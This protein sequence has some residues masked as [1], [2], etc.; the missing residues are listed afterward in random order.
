MTMKN[1]LRTLVS[2]GQVSLTLADTTEI[3]RE[4]IKL[5]KLSP[6]SAIVFGKAISAMTFMSACLKEETGEISLSVQSDGT[7]GGMLLLGLISA[8]FA[9]FVLRKK[10]F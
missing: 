9:L 5:H 10:H 7:G 8:T 4:G 6:A 3:V 2:E 1:V